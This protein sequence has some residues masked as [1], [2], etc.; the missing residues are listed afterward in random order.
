MHLLLGAYWVR[1]QPLLLG[2]ENDHTLGQDK[3][4]STLVEVYNTLINTKISQAARGEHDDGYNTHLEVYFL[5]DRE[6]EEEKN[7]PETI[8]KRY[9]LLC[10]QQTWTW[11]M[12][13]PGK[14][15]AGE[16]RPQ[17]GHDDREIDREQQ[18]CR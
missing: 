11:A 14:D 15:C 16:L 1:F 8:P 3:Y 18:S 5:Q 2:L 13:A 17:R 9:D 6:I 4:P 10:M 7:P 12:G